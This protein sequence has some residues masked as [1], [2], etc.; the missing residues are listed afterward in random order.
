MLPNR[1]VC[2]A[3]ITAPWYRLGPAVLSL[4]AI[5]LIVSPWVPEHETFWVDHF[6]GKQK[7][8]TVSEP[9]R[10]RCE[11]FLAMKV[12]N[13]RCFQF[14]PPLGGLALMIDDGKLMKPVTVDGH[15]LRT[16]W[17]G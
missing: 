5:L 4:G 1:I 11:L 9:I 15:P 8:W 7:V 13:W 2:N 14:N 3:A 17:D 6:S 12:S 10:G 16:N